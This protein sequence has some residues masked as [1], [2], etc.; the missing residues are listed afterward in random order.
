[1]K[2]LLPYLLSPFHIRPGLISTVMAGNYKNIGWKE[3]GHFQPKLH[4]DFHTILDSGY[5]VI[6]TILH[7]Y[8]WSVY[9]WKKVVPDGPALT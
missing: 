9:S 7:I 3:S 1:M 6:L 4:T 2:D 8:Y 5:L